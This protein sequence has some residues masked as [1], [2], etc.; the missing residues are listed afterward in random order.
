MVCWGNDNYGDATVPDELASVVHIGTGIWQSCALKTDGTVVCWGYSYGPMPAGLNLGVQDNTPPVVTYIGNAG[1]HTVDQVVAIT[2]TPSD[3]LSGVA[4]STCAAINGGAHNFSVGANTFSATATDNAGNVGGAT[5]TFMVTVT[6]GSL[7][8]LVRRWV[9]N[10][11]VANS[12]CVKLDQ[13]SYGA[14]RNELRAQA[15]KKISDANAAVL[16]RLISV[17]DPE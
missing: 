14:F 10:S 9:S 1:S 11:G 16:L 13:A 3:D 2:C 6:S 4:S 15:G 12:M 17:L 7:C 8:R 5:T